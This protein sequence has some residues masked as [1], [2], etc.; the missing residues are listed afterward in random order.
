MN[1]LHSND[2]P[3]WKELAPVLDEAIEELQ[4]PDREAIVLRFFEQRDLRAIGDFLGI[5]DDAAQKRVSRALEKL[6]HGLTQRGVSLSI[7]ALSALLASSAVAAPGGWASH[8]ASRALESAVSKVPLVASLTA[9]L[10]LPLAKVALG[11]AVAGL[12]TTAIVFRHRAPTPPQS[13]VASLKGAVTAQEIAAAASPETSSAA[14]S[15]KAGGSSMSSRSLVLTI[16]A[17]DSNQP[18]PNVPIEFRGW[19]QNKFSGKKLAANRLGICEVSYPS[20]ITDLELTAR[21]DDFADTKLHWRPDRGDKIPARYTLRLT[22]PIEIS[23]RVVNE[24]DEPVAEAKVGFNHEE[25][26]ITGAMTESHDFSWIEVPTDQQGHWRINRIAPEMIRRLYGSARHPDYTGSKMIFL[27]RDSAQEEQL[28]SGTHVFRLGNAVI[29]HGYVVNSKGIALPEAKVLVGHQSDADSRTVTTDAEGSF[30]ARGCRPGK[31]LVSAEAKGYAPSTIEADLSADMQPIR[32]TLVE[33]KVLRL[34]VVDRAGHPIPKA[35]VW[36]NTFNDGPNASSAPQIQTDF[37]PLTD[38]E[39]RVVWNEA[40]DA[41]L[42]FDVQAA[43]YMRFSNYKVHPDG[44]EH[45]ITL[46]PAL[47]IK[48]TVVDS[49]KG[50]PIPHFRITSGWPETALGQEKQVGHWSTLERFTVAFNDGKFEHS[51][52]EP[53]LSGTADPAFMFKFEAEGYAPFISRVV[54]ANEGTVQ[55]E[56]RLQPSAATKITVLLPNRQPAPNTAVAFATPQQHISFTPGGFGRHNNISYVTDTGG[57]ISWQRDE[58]VM[59]II[60]VNPSGF[61][62]ATPEELASDPTLQLRAWGRVEGTVTHRGKPI[63]GRE[64]RLKQYPNDLNGAGARLD[65]D[66]HIKTD[67]T[68]AFLFDKAPPGQFSL[69]YLAPERE[70]NVFTHAPMRDLIIRPGES[71][72]VNYAEQGVT[73]TVRARWPEGV[74]RESKQSVFAAIQSAD[75]PMPPAEIANDPKALGEW[76]QLPEIQ[77]AYRKVRSYILNENTPGLWTAENVDPGD[78]TANFSVAID[79]DAGQT[80]SA[81]LQGVRQLSIAADGTEDSLDLGE[82]TLQKINSTR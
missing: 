22:R 8:I 32:L 40:P 4:G 14:A 54:K 29:V 52:D 78:Y 33:G 26:P 10:G 36:L 61:A 18:V 49:A 75:R 2:E 80:R 45:V 37:S 57:Q 7:A 28:R 15:D 47:T 69:F 6:R 34:L 30:E 53:V 9:L 65:W 31:T 21:V 25:D 42:A 58:T 67:A 5:S 74:L 56:V 60:A 12:L 35:N 43:K 73:V 55:L 70:P 23:G 11:L 17:A 20:N 39:G 46:Q 59:Q 68:G 66:I 38:S 16:L 27:A 19:E 41:D 76:V 50:S 3:A 82:L 48:G 72:T 64:L 63:A 51:F 13:S 62:Q 44:E 81:V 24:E 71:T 79:G 1:N 77:E